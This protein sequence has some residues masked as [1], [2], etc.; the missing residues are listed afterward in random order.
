MLLKLVDRCDLSAKQ[1]VFHRLLDQCYSVPLIKQTGTGQLTSLIESL[2]FV[3]V[4]VDNRTLALTDDISLPRVVFISKRDEHLSECSYM[5]KEVFQCNMSSATCE[6]CVGTMA[7]LG[8]GFFKTETDDSPAKYNHW[9]VLNIQGNYQPLWSFVKIFANCIICEHDPSD[10]PDYKLDDVPTEVKVP[11]LKWQNNGGRRILDKKNL[12]ISGSF[13]YVPKEMKRAVTGVFKKYKF[14]DARRI[15][16]SHIQSPELL[17]TDEII[18]LDLLDAN[19]AKI[20]FSEIRGELDL[21]KVFAKQSEFA[22]AM[23]LIRGDQAQ[24]AV[25]RTS[26]DQEIESSKTKALNR[27]ELPVLSLFYNVLNLKDSD[28][29]IVALNQFE[30]SIDKGCSEVLRHEREKVNEA[31][32]EYIRVKNNPDDADAALK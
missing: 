22:L 15:P 4:K 6:A 21:Q 1:E 17:R 20:S 23:Q 27:M 25:L 30:K 8:I 32:Q 7:E 5:A 2:R 18:G 31:W 16:L 10:N 9:P 29:R 13:H 26:I 24:E 19:I 28:L 3:Q 14:G 11:T 12:K